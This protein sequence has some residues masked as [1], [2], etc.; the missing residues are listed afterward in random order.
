MKNSMKNLLL[1]AFLVVASTTSCL[2]QRA[3]DQA[4]L[5]AMSLAW[6]GV[7][8]DLERGLADAVEDGD[9]LDQAP[10]DGLVAQL[11]AALDSG[12]RAQLVLIPWESTLL[13][14]AER[15]I[16]DRI[17]DGEMSDLV[18]ESLRERLRNFTAGFGKLIV[19]NLPREHWL[20]NGSQV[21]HVG[22]VTLAGKLITTNPYVLTT[23]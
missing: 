14:Y 12:S 21:T 22:T 10:L 6:V 11:D 18:A 13:P 9:L 15:G 8:A 16:Q 23:D 5:P 20:P 1:M 3:R 4:L 17:D 7:R 2:S 19:T